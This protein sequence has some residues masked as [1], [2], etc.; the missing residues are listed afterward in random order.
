MI[1][2][3]IYLAVGNVSGGDVDKQIA[4]DA[5]GARV[6]ERPFLLDV[7]RLIWRVWSGR[8]PTGIDR[9]CLAY[10]EHF[11][12]RSRAV[13]QRS[14]RQYILSPVCSD[15][16]FSLLMGGGKAF[17]RRFTMLAA[18]ALLS[19]I[20]KRLEGSI[21]YLNV[22]HT[23]L[24]EVGLPAWVERLGLRAVFLIHDLIPLTHPEFCRAGEAEKHSRRMSNALRCAS[25][26]I[27]NSQ[28]TVAD[29]NDFADAK[30]V[31]IPPSLV[32]WIAGH[33]L[34]STIAPA[35]IS[36]PYFVSIGTIE[37]RK[38]HVL[39]LQLWKRLI[40]RHGDKAPMLVI[41]G[42]RGWE[43][44]HALAMLDRA[45]S[46]QGHVLELNSASDGELA[47]Y[48]AGARALL[49]PSF[50]EGFG[51]PVVEALQLG[52]PVIASDLEVF[53]EIAGD[54]PNYLD[55]SDGAGWEK[56]VEDFLVDGQERQRQLAL[57]PSYIA[58]TWQAHFERVEQWLS[59]LP[60]RTLQGVSRAC[61]PVRRA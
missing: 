50:A 53:R 1:A 3:S 31:T 26:I 60:G 36:R 28:M 20:E 34:P 11:G 14:G 46:L 17:R 15:A 6:S 21:A 12:S 52:T 25:G 33:A 19:G 37:G 39:L 35:P 16:L 49:M 9:V 61:E 40:Q 38:N 51:I 5:R 22:G 55:S 13:V 27:A 58:P 10:V 32:A 7:S 42:Q 48:I 18:R 44:E 2:P 41:I 30:G 43:A 4:T 47:G 59:E 23:G 45:P 24:D 56:A 8:I 54:I 57:L 29:L